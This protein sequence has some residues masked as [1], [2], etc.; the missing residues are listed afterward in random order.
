MVLLSQA[1]LVLDGQY[2]FREN[3]GRKFLFANVVPCLRAI[4]RNELYR[5]GLRYFSES[6]PHGVSVFV[7][8]CM[9][10]VCRLNSR[11]HFVDG[12]RVSAVGD[13]QLMHL[14]ILVIALGCIPLRAFSSW[15]MFCCTLAVIWKRHSADCFSALAFQRRDVSQHLL[16]AAS[17]FPLL[18][19]VRYHQRCSAFSCAS[20]VFVPWFRCV[21]FQLFY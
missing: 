17:G 14:C 20:P 4:F 12:G 9:S 21:I 15:C 7:S 1:I 6:I 3:A 10:A 2:I 13:R 5:E 18:A 16:H 8:L 11:K 19:V